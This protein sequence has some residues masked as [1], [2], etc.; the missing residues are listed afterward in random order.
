MFAISMNYK[1]T[2]TNTRE[3]Y[4]FD[5]DTAL[6]FLKRLRAGGMEEIV[7]LNTCNRTEVYGDGD[8][9]TALKELAAFGGAEASTLREDAFIYEGKS[10]IRHLFRVTAGMESMVVGEDEV[11][12]QMKGAYEFSREQGFTGYAFNKVFQAAITAAKRIK[13][14][15]R[16]S[17]SSVSVATL[18]AN[19]CHRFKEGHKEILVIGASGDTGNKLVK[20]LISYHDCSIFATVRNRHVTD[21]NLT[22]VPYEERYRYIDCADVIVSC[23]KSPHYTVTYAQIK[24][25]Q[26]REKPRLFVDLAVPRDI[27]E[28][29][30]KLAGSELI[31]INDIEELAREN[32]EIKRAELV[33]AEEI[34]EEAVDELLKTLSWHEFLSESV[35]MKAEKEMDLSKFIYHYRDVSSAE[36][37][38]NFLNV[39]RRMEE[40][41]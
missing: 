8:Y 32:N 31:T 10:A 37:F 4:A 22:L 15:T 29:V 26:V 23:T 14:D 40:D 12:G 25:E 38:G 35:W 1:T 27:D 28:D 16:L 5:Q 11:L 33:T 9:E 36:E 13:T 30:S 34:I 21:R 17:K 7:Y 19:R 18:A 3:Q 6:L 20:N 24:R 39:L 41:A 2:K